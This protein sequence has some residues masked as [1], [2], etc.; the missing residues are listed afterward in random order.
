MKFTT[1]LPIVA[2]LALGMTGSIVHAT[3][4]A[5][6]ESAEQAE[7]V[8][9]S[10]S[11]FMKGMGSAMRAFTNYLKRGDGEP[12]ELGS[13]AAEIAKNAPS[14]PDLFPKDTGMAQFEDSEAKAVIWEKWDDFV[15]AANGLVEPAMAVEAAF[16]SGD[17]GEVAASVKALGGNGCRTCHETFRQKKDN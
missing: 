9:E 10:R 4:P 2:L 3:E 12:I 8:L 17:K 6:V 7:A 11:E 13:M 1:K 5:M 14:I 16:E 15:D